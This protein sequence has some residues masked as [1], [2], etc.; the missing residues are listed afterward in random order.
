M[1]RRWQWTREKRIA[2][3]LRDR[4]QTQQEIA[5][6]LGVTRRTVE[7]WMRRP[8][9][10]AYAEQRERGDLYARLAINDRLL[11][12][13]MAKHEALQRHFERQFEEVLQ[14]VTQS[15]PLDAAARRGTR[16]PP[17]EA[18]QQNDVDARRRPPRKRDIVEHARSPLVTAGKSATLRTIWRQ[19]TGAR[20]R[21]RERS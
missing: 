4:G 1:P 9:W 17:H 19:E 5:V 18:P 16:A 14:S 15:S 6:A 7:G 10:R 3:V 20:I 11:R 2:F 12:I 13:D 8:A 21:E